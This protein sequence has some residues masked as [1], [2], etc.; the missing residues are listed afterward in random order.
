[1]DAAGAG[2]DR[3]RIFVYIMYIPHLQKILIYF[4]VYA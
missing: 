4:Y 3:R 1:M 2:A